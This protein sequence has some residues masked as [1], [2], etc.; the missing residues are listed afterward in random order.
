MLRLFLIAVV[1]ATLCLLTG[2]GEGSAK[3]GSTKPKA[4]PAAKKVTRG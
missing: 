4:K 3:A 1:T 2:C